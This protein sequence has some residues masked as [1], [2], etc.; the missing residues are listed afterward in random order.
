MVHVVSI[1]CI[2][3]E[4]VVDERTWRCVNG[5]SVMDFA[6]LRYSRHPPRQL[7]YKHN[8]PF[9]ILWSNEHITCHLSLFIRNGIHHTILIKV[10]SYKNILKHSVYELQHI[11]STY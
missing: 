4:V 10:F 1:G 6:P 3:V 8:S 11:L 5:D 7:S 9:L 2:Q